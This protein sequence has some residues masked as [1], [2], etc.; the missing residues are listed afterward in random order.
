MMLGELAPE[1]WVTERPLRRALGRLVSGLLCASA[2]RWSGGP[3]RS[4]TSTWIAAFVGD[5]AAALPLGLLGT[6]LL[7]ELGFRAAGLLAPF[8]RAVGFDDDVALVVLCVGDS[9]TGETATAIRSGSAR[10]LPIEARREQQEVRPHSP[11]D[12]D[13]LRRDR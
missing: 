13:P 2:L 1:L 8:G 3:A 4:G 12:P 5:R 9:H 6:L 11:P 10:C 7:V